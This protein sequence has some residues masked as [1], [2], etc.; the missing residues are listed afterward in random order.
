MNIAGKWISC[1]IQ[2]RTKDPLSRKTT[3]AK[4]QLQFIPMQYIKCLLL[5]YWKQDSSLLNLFLLASRESTACA[6]AH[7][8][9]FS[10]TGILGRTLDFLKCFFPALP[11]VCALLFHDPLAAPGSNCILA[12]GS[13]N[14]QRIKSLIWYD[15]WLTFLLKE[16]SAKNGEM[17]TTACPVGCLGVT[18]SRKPSKPSPTSLRYVTVLWPPKALC[19]YLFLKPYNLVQ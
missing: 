7:H 17:N 10:K 1:S 11:S 8:S 6:P 18:T 3:E 19:A 12:Q 14:M 4:I 15:L 5:C 13:G 2:E 16:C 9:A